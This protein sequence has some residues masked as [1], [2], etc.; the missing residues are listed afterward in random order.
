MQT[1]REFL[2]TTAATLAAT[3]AAGAVPQAPREIRSPLNAP[4]GLQLYSLKSYLPKD[5]PGTLA[6]IRSMGFREVEGAGLWGKTV[7]ELRQAL[8]AAGLRCQSA[9]MGYERL[10]D[11]LTGAL[12]DARGVGATWVVCPWIPHEG[13]I[14]RDQIL[15]AADL[16]TRAA[17]AATQQ[18]MRF[19]YHLHGYEFIPSEEGNLFD[20]LARN[21][22]QKL[23]EFQ[24]D[25]FHTFHGGGDP[26]KVIT[27]Y[28]P[29]VTSLH[30][31]DLKKGSAI[32][33]GT[34]T[35]TP[36][37]DVPV[38]TGA[39]DMPAVLRAAMKAATKFYYL[40]DESADPLNNIPQSLRFLETVKL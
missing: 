39:I 35:G 40:E 38:G 32:V 34:G 21:T 24:V 2:T 1:R 29:R 14:T 6:K 23:V 20:T 18:G 27:Q 31:K 15:R 8:D 16:F 30:L 5:L 25:V 22:D 36:D 17:R 11:D 37:L 3:A 13:A 28:A 4:I 33:P 12:A 26:V 9:H 10:R 19:G 7:Q